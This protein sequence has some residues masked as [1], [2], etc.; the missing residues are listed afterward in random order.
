MPGA[1]YLIILNPRWSHLRSLGATWGSTP[2]IS[3]STAKPA[4]LLLVMV[5]IA[6]LVLLLRMQHRTAVHSTW[7]AKTRILQIRQQLLQ[8]RASQA[9]AMRMDLAAC[10]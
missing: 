7:L 10:L 5:M 6:S 9:H 8:T 3:C 2:H 4:L 1:D